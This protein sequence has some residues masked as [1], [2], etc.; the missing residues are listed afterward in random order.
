MKR[1]TLKSLQW[2]IG[3]APDKR[4][5]ARAFYGL[6]VFHDNNSREA[7]AIPNYQ[8]AIRLGLGKNRE[9][10][11]RAW[12]A[13]SFFKTGRPKQALRECERAAKIVKS[14]SLRKFI[15]GLEKRIRRKGCQLNLLDEA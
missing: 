8:K 14:A 10:M 9:A 12:L 6:G 15:S 5:Q 2:A 4:G 7:M 1:R 11:A 13:S 3:S